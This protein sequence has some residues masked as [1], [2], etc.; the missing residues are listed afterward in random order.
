M[1]ETGLAGN[2]QKFSLRCLRDVTEEEMA[3]KR[4]GLESIGKKF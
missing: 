1:G 3:G 2:N 4:H